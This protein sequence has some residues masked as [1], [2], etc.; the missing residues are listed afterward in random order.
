M[1]KD[2]FAD[3]LLGAGWR[4]TADAQYSGIYRLYDELFP[5]VSHN[6]DN[7]LTIAV[8]ALAKIANRE[9]CMVTG[10]NKTN[11]RDDCWQCT[12]AVVEKAMSDIGR[13]IHGKKLSAGCEE[14]P[15]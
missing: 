5:V 11:G 14:C 6:C 4:N 8:S 3:M 2:K 1:D 15:F 12:D 9:Y 10:C 13:C 7:E